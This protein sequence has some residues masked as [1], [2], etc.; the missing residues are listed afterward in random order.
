V[1][2]RLEALDQE[3]AR[4]GQ[5]AAADEVDGVERRLAALGPEAADDG[6]QRQMRQLLSSQREMAL[7]WATRKERKE[8][9]RVLL[10]GHLEAIWSELESLCSLG[11]GS[12]SASDRLRVL[13]A[14]AEVQ[15]GDV[16]PSPA[17]TAVAPLEDAPTLDVS[18]DQEPS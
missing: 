4:L 1:L 16:T 15:A 5:R 13:C 17:D 10:L 3:I 11:S 12:T 9:E 7:R 6:E 18:K 14:E 2:S 8:A